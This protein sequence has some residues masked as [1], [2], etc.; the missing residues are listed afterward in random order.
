MFGTQQGEWGYNKTF[1]CPW[2]N[3]I[4]GKYFNAGS[5][6]SIIASTANAVRDLVPYPDIE[7]VTA[8]QVSLDTTTQ[9]EF[10]QVDIGLA[11]VTVTADNSVEDISITTTA[12]V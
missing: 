1:G 6:L 8:S 9:A 3:G 12:A 10:R 4:F 5:T 2:R 11:R 7:P